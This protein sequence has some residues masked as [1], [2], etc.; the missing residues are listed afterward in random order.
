MLKITLGNYPLILKKRN[1]DKNTHLI[2]FK[3]L[4][5]ILIPIQDSVEISSKEKYNFIINF[6]VESKKLGYSLSSVLIREL[7]SCD[8]ITS[9][10][11]ICETYL[12]FM[13]NES[14]LDTDF[15]VM[16]E[17]FPNQVLSVERNNLY[18]NALMHYASDGKFFP[19]ATNDERSPL[20]EDT[21]LTLIGSCDI[22]DVKGVLNNILNSKESL[23][24]QDKNLL[25]NSLDMCSD[26]SL[27]EYKETACIVAGEFIRKGEKVP[28]NLIK[29]STDVLRVCTYLSGGDVSLSTNTKFI[30]FKRK[31]RRLILSMLESLIKEEDIKRHS[32]KWGK[33]FH[34]LH[35][36]EYKDSFTRCYLIALKLRKNKTLTSFNTNIERL[37]NDLSHIKDST[38]KSE[39]IIPKLTTLLSSRPT[40]FARR[41]D[42]ILTECDSEFTQIF[43]LKEFKKVVNGVDVKILLQLLGHFKT[44]FTAYNEKFIIPKS[45]TQN[46][47]IVK[48]DIKAIHTYALTQLLGVIQDEISFKLGGK[49]KMGNV[50]VDSRLDKIFLPSQ[51]RSASDSKFTLAR[52]SRIPFETEKDVIRMFVYWVGQDIDLSAQ[53]L[54]DEFNSIGHVSYT[55]LRSG[56]FDS[57][58]SGD[59]TAAPNGASEFIDVNTKQSFEAGARYIVMSVRVYS[60]DN[61][62]EHDTVYCGWMGREKPNSG[63]IYEPSTVQQKV[64]LTGES[65][66]SI[67]AIFDLKTKEV[68]WVDIYNT[69][70]V[71]KPNNIE[72]NF[73]STRETVKFFVNRKNQVTLLE[74]VT[75]NARERGKIVQDIDDADI[76]FSLD[77]VDGKNTVTPFNINYINSELI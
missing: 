34:G 27:V 56:K 29:N 52:G 30:S 36:G 77:D 32:G 76:I 62:S 41:L 33:L 23:S 71:G 10:K 22:D 70:R 72:S 8:N 16:Y 4:K 63:E 19:D 24:E 49:S 26:F 47:R 53:F 59:I 14:G 25:I 9:L 69:D 68:V 64:S 58:H 2:A 1:M 42:K 20:Y 39:Q 12:E 48:K 13:Y 51:Q 11:K 45:L 38:I 50:Y 54:D 15:K 31:Q 17:G 6:I 60:G 57:Y 21:N 55:K 43:V 28:D 7:F 73:A 66:T 35:V 44:R 61:F 37:I 74:L 3:K 5:S 18:Y 67:P 75:M 46:I 40:E 65:R